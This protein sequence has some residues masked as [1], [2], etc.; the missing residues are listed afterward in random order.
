MALERFKFSVHRNMQQLRIT[1]NVASTNFPEYLH[2]FWRF[3]TPRLV[4][5]SKTIFEQHD[6]TAIWWWL[7]LFEWLESSLSR[8]NINLFFCVS[9]VLNK[10]EFDVDCAWKIRRKKFL[11]VLIQLMTQMD[12]PGLKT[13]VTDRGQKYARHIIGTA[14]HVIL[15]LW[16]SV[17]S[18][19]SRVLFQRDCRVLLG[20]SL[21]WYFIF[22]YF[23]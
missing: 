22:V 19:L 3:K 8:V 12:L 13:I 11:F 7:P 5:I 23:H 2:C 21:T 1:P 10:I 15:F 17:S 9:L 18:H 6:L 20:F 16:S 14:N 4:S